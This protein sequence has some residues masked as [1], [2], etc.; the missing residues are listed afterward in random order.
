MLV[1]CDLDGTL[2]CLKYRITRAG[3]PPSREDRKAFTEWLERLQVPDDMLQ[4]KVILHVAAI[5]EMIVK[6]YNDTHLVYLT[7]REEKYRDVT[8]EWMRKH[9]LPDGPLYMRAGGRL[10]V[11]C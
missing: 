2:A 3:A 7:S 1:L 10:A 9:D 4:D 8:R 5:V 11:V 6:H